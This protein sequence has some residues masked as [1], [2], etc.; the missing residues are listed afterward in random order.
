MM[1][2]YVNEGELIV[3]YSFASVLEASFTVYPIPSRPCVRLA[4]CAIPISRFVMDAL[5]IWKLSVK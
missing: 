2:G 1:L 4:L 5:P 3:E